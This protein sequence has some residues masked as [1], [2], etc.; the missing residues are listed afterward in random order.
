MRGSV[1]S[2][3][4]QATAQGILEP[5]H[6]FTFFMENT[7]SAQKRGQSCVPI[8]H[9]RVTSWMIRSYCLY[10]PLLRAPPPPSSPHSP[11]TPATKVCPRALRPAI[12]VLPPAFSVQVL[13]SSPTAWLS[14]QCPLPLLNPFQISRQ[15]GTLMEKAQTHGGLQCLQ[16]PPPPWPL[17]SLT[18]SRPCPVPCSHA[19]FLFS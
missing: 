18:L 3:P 10:L 9:L 7:E 17:P 6:V 19:G 1:C 13:P 12:W 14:S 16:A 15:V 2:A 11:L 8:A 5:W 4:S